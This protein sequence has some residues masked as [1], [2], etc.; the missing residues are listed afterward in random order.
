M[1]SAWLL[2]IL[3]VAFSLASPPVDTPTSSPTT[4]DTSIVA[5]MSSGLY[6][7]LGF[8]RDRQPSDPSTAS[9][10][11]GGPPPLGPG[12]FPPDEVQV[13][14]TSDHDVEPVAIS[15]TIGPQIFTAT[16]F[17]RMPNPPAGREY[18]TLWYTRRYDY[19]GSILGGQLPV[20][21]AYHSYADPFLAGNLF[22]GGLYPNR[23]YNVGIMHNGQ[24]N[25]GSAIGL[26]PSDDGGL[27][28]G[29][30]TVVAN[31]SSGTAFL[32]FPKVAV[33][34]NWSSMGTVYVMFSRLVLAPPGSVEIYVARSV[35]GGASFAPPVQVA[36]G[37]S[38]GGHAVVVEPWTGKVVA[39]WIDYLAQ[40]IKMSQSPDLGASWLAAQV[41][42]TPTSPHTF[43]LGYTSDGIRIYTTLMAAYNYATGQLGMV[44]HEFGGSTRG[45]IFFS[46][47]DT[48]GVWRAKSLVND[49]LTNDQFFPSIAFNNAGKGLIAFYDRRDDPTNEAF[50]LYG[51]TLDAAGN[52]GANFP[53]TQF[54]S[55]ARNYPQNFVGDYQQTCSW[56]YPDGREYV[57][58]FV[59][60]KTDLNASDADIFTLY[61][62]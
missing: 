40:Q 28:W 50:R 35:D 37:P 18:P 32:D 57:S 21:P 31:D 16:V 58:T 55:K 42:F 14:F 27:T 38:L 46:L 6:Y 33:S 41:I 52:L 17:L 19:S 29:G 7:S 59:G 1:S 24:G 36:S 15:T 3:A 22:G 48:N 25:P 12:G 62:W 49:V 10:V 54:S 9:A 4:T 34:S 43:F 13:S 26:W 39:L 61:V 5:S 53:M 30:P 51:V 44:W 56:E 11:G 47:R 45:D 23:I 20:S 60:N 8:T 2:R